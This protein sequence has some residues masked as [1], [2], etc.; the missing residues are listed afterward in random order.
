MQTYT[1]DPEY[2]LVYPN[3]HTMKL[4]GT[5]RCARGSMNRNGQAHQY[6][7]GKVQKLRKTS[8]QAMID[9]PGAKRNGWTL[10]GRCCK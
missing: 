7:G 2:F 3:H 4:H 6:G 9:E 8:Y 1:K 10:C 5:K